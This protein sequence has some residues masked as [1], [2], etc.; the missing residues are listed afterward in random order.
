LTLSGESPAGGVYSGTGVSVGSFDPAVSGTGTFVITYVYTDVNACSDTA[1]ENIVVDACLGL[2]ANTALGQ[3]SIYPNPSKGL[4]T[5]ITQSNNALLF[6][7]DVNGKLVKQ[8]QMRYENTNVDLH[9]LTA[10]IYTFR[11][12]STETVETFKVVLEK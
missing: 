11:L 2:S 1:Q 8:Q 6:V 7:Y 9:E 5:V 3:N 12:Q 4:V 10:G